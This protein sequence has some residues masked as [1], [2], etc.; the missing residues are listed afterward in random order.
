[1]NSSDL[2]ECSRCHA[3]KAILTY[4]GKV[5]CQ[6]C[7]ERLKPGVSDPDTGPLRW[8]QRQDVMARIVR[9]IAIVIAIGSL[10]IVAWA[11]VRHDENCRARGGTPV[12]SGKSH[13]CQMPIVGWP[14]TA[15]TQPRPGAP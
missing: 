10:I 7:Y 15:S 12:P 9:L 2:G 13:R 6:K 1:M 11:Q 3:A 8:W 5:L 4:D 14:D